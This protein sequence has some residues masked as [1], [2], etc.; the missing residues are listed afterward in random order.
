MNWPRRLGQRKND[1]EPVAVLLYPGGRIA[2]NAQMEPSQ[3][4]VQDLARLES[5][6]I[7]LLIQDKCR[8]GDRLCG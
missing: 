7:G 2:G 4:D 8:Q 1:L 3:R 5:F 6:R